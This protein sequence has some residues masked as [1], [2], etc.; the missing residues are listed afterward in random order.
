[1]L[2]VVSGLREGAG[3]RLVDENGTATPF[4]PYEQGFVGRYGDPLTTFV[5][6]RVNE[7]APGT[8]TY[9]RLYEGV[10]P[11]Q[12]CPGMV[13]PV[14]DG[15]YYCLGKEYGYCD[16]RSGTCFCNVGY[17]GISC[18]DCSSTHYSQGGLCYPKL[19]CPGDCSGAG[20]C[21]YSNGT[22]SCL[23]HRVGDDCSLPYC[24]SIFSDRCAECTSEACTSCES[25]YFV[26]EAGGGYECLSCG[27]HD[28]RCTRCN[29]E[30]CLE[31]TDLLL[32]SIRR[33]GARGSDPP[34]PF[35]ELERELPHSL[36]FGTKDP[37]Y[38]A[39]AEAFDVV[40]NSSSPLNETS[41]ACAQGVLGDDSWT[42]ESR[43]ISHRVC[44]NP[45]TL[46]FS[47]PEYQAFEDP[48]AAYADDQY[49][50]RY[51]TNGT[52]RITVW[53]TGGGYGT[54]GVRYRLQ[55]GTTDEADVTPHAHY[56]TSNALVFAPGEV[57]LSFLLSVHEDGEPENNEFFYLFLYDPWGGARLGAQQRTLVTV[58]DAQTNSSAIDHTLTTFYL[59]QGEGEAGDTH[60]IVAGAVDNVTIV[61]KD[62]LGRERGFGGD[63]FAVWVEAKRQGMLD[64][65]EEFE[66]RVTSVDASDGTYA[67]LPSAVAAM[68]R[69][70]DL[71][72]G[73]Y[74]LSYQVD[75]A[76]TYF[77]RMALCRPGGLTGR[78][79]SDSFFENEMVM[80]FTWGSGAIAGTASNFA[81]VSWSGRIRPDYTETFEVELATVVGEG[82]AARL[83]IDGVVVVDGFERGLNGVDWEGADEGLGGGGRGYVNLTAG[84]L[85]EIYI[86]YSERK[87]DASL[88]LAWS[89]PSVSYQVVPPLNLFWVRELGGSPRALS[90]RSALTDGEKSETFGG[91]TVSAVAALPSTLTIQ[92]RDAFGNLRIDETDTDVAESESGRFLV[93]LEAVDYDSGD[94]LG[95]VHGSAGSGGKVVTGTVELV[96]EEG[97]LV[98]EYVPFVA[99]T[100][101]LNVTFQE[102]LF[103]PET[104]VTGSPFT[105][106]VSPGEAFGRRSDAWGDALSNIT[107]GAVAN[108]TVR[109]R[110]VVGNAIWEGGSELEVYA[111]H[112]EVEVGCDAAL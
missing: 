59:G 110:D 92:P 37:H 64:G 39:S 28:P 33:S 35:D 112:Q 7:G 20:T 69:V 22:C 71:G 65:E 10:Y 1:L 53:R 30:S 41:V 105:V 42:C 78:Y 75:I 108:L 73:N 32:L 47:S 51:V 86:E 19:V 99:G 48:L 49:D 96:L 31:C 101:L 34:L 24:P 52:V 80:N 100:H 94:T 23:D 13:G 87:G 58:V 61:T 66:V 97:V 43:R 60:A 38:F 56:T 18:Q 8:P 12:I 109:A 98:A 46:S 16:R 68:T 40:S 103:E 106:N 21:H 104:H 45:G 27:L 82:D 29:E 63:V 83:W 74:T 9:P 79:T 90:V 3:F 26:D 17:Q 107:A 67:G 50:E 62:A 93:V 76:G 111:F 102:W 14:D 70:Q 81:G 95:G 91:G 54:V 4:V 89:S 44:G 77:L 2:L 55:H 5:S 25:G 85:H 36:E 57:E 72:S 15:L 84:N 11:R 6:D 88:H